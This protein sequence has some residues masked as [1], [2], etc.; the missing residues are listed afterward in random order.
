MNKAY[1]IECSPLYRMRNRRKLA[2]VLKLDEKYFKQEHTY[3]YDHFSKP[4]LNG[5]GTRNFTVPEEELKNIQ[6]RICKLMSKI[7]TPEWVISGKKNQSYISNA[8][9]HCRNYNVKTMDISRFYDSAKRKYVYNMFKE[10][11]LM[12]DDISWIM[13]NLVMYG[14]ILPTGSPT[15]QLVV[16]WS[17]SDMFESI[18]EIARK[19]KC[20]FTLYVDD[21]TFSSNIGI[22]KQLRKDVEEILNSYCLYAKAKK[23]HYYQN[24]AFKKVTGVGIKKGKMFVPNQKR[25]EIIEMYKTCLKNKNIIE[26]EKLKGLI[27]SARQIEPG[28]FPEIYR[29]IEKYNGD[30][31][32]LARN[33]YYCN[34]R[35]RKKTQCYEAVAVV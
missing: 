24:N 29:F 9:K 31:K 26:I 32:V 5:E 8:R 25:Y 20:E 14:G 21:M 17:Y 19:Y 4:K 23:D 1:P 3:K 10:K 7:E 12:A 18:Y 6:K 11:F 22:S 15:S 27:I 34:M 28:I 13:T 30:L 35:K 33:R 2:R 16:Y